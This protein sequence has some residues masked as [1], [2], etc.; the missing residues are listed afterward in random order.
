M[1]QL[2]LSWT[3][4]WL[5]GLSVR[6]SIHTACTPPSHL[7]E[8]CP[9]SNKPVCFSSL[10]AFTIIDQNRDGIISKDDLRDVLASMGEW[11]R[12]QITAEELMRLVLHGL[13][14]GFRSAEREEWGAGG[15]DQG[16]QRPHQL[17]RL[18]HHVRRE[19]EGWESHFYHHSQMIFT[20]GRRNQSL[21]S[22]QV[23]E[24]SPNAS[25]KYLF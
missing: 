22:R 18:P 24:K 13:L 19:A 16:G 21:I 9:S 4:C 6:W 1:Q 17:H 25:T 23:V 14:S 10:Q 8:V 12:D 7:S 15:H 20:L 2:P 11:K 5:R 3:N